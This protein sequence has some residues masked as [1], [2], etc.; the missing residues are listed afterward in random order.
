MN[1]LRPEANVPHDRLYDLEELN[2]QF[3]QAYVDGPECM[4]WLPGASR[5]G[6][7]ECG[8]DCQNL[9][10]TD[11]SNLPYR[12]AP[13]SPQHTNDSPASCPPKQCVSFGANPGW[14]LLEIK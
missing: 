12:K 1:V 6:Q 4:E 11:L 14:D 9:H 7:P 3:E 8:A 13:W 5:A 10:P 2:D